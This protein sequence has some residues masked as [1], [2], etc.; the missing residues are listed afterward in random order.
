M[1]ETIAKFVIISFGIF[2]IA[3]GL[4]MAFRPQI[5]RSMLRKAGS[6]T[7]INYAEL[8]IRM[9]PGI[10]FIVYAETSKFPLT[11][12]LVGWFIL[13]SSILLMIIPRRL[14]HQFSLGAA[15]ILKPI[16]FQLISPLSILIGV[17]II[18]TVT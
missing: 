10:A 9:I 15:E 1:P 18:Y 6:T 8:S 5:A 3:A 4:I 2:F 14:H 12:Q 17:L 16:Y 11:F 13:I 7:F